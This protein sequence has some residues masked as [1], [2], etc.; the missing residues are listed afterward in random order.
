MTGVLKRCAHLSEVALFAGQRTERV[1]GHDMHRC[2]A[3]LVEAAAVLV[4]GL[5]IPRVRQCAVHALGTRSS[6]APAPQPVR[7]C[8]YREA[9]YMSKLPIFFTFIISYLLHL[10]RQLIEGVFSCAAI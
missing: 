4:G 10:T 7:Y 9:G 8:L 1:G 6:A 3:A 2:A 5:L